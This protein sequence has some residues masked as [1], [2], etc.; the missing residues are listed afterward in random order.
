MTDNDFLHEEPPS[1]GG[2]GKPSPLHEYL[3][4]FSPCCHPPTVPVKKILGL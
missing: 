1:Y 2:G 3:T 4:Q